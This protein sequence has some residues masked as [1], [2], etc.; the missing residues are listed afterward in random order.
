MIKPL[1]RLTAILFTGIA[2]I[3]CIAGIILLIVLSSVTM[4][5]VNAADSNLTSQVINQVVDTA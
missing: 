3:T 4:S 5:S 1:Q 2:D